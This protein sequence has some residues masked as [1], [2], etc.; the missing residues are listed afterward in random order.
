MAEKMKR[1]DVEFLDTMSTVVEVV[2]VDA[3]KQKFQDSFGDADLLV[4]KEI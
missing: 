4:I 2:S 3:A 1:F